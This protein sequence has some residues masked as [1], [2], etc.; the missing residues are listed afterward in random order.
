MSSRRCIECKKV[1]ERECSLCGN[2]VCFTCQIIETHD[3]KG[4]CEILRKLR[5]VIENSGDVIC[6]VDRD[7]KFEFVSPACLENW[8]YEPSELVG[9]MFVEIIFPVDRL[10]LSAF[11]REI[12]ARQAYQ[13]GFESRVIRKDGTEHKF[14]WSAHWS[15]KEQSMFMVA[16]DIAQRKM[17]EE[18]IKTSEARVRSIIDQMLVG[19]LLLTPKGII[20]SVNPRTQTMFG[21]KAEEI[22]GRHLLCLFQESRFLSEY[23]A[24]DCAQFIETFYEK[25]LG[26]LGALSGLTKQGKDLPVEIIISEFNQKEGLRYLAN[27]IDVSQRADC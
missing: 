22:V 21:F 5:T 20:E 19:L 27:I 25:T 15:S 2:Y 7:G 16:H 8:H 6:S 9:R 11:L 14:S 3:R 4:K 12:R 1:T 26:C 18:A 17:V 23:D 10:G 24:N 13:C